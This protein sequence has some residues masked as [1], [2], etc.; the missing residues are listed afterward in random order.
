MLDESVRARVSFVKHNFLEPLPFFDG[1][2][3][4]V[5]V[6]CVNSGMPGKQ[7]PSLPGNEPA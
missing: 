2:F 6:A 5:R 4:Y 3:D 1:E 7:E